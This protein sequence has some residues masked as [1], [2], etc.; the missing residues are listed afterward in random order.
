VTREIF[1]ACASSPG[2]R[3][4]RT[5][6]RNSGRRTPACTVAMVLASSPVRGTENHT[7]RRRGLEHAVDHETVEVFVIASLAVV[8]ACAPANCITGQSITIDSGMS[9]AL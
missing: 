2:S 5:N 1:T 9:V 8:L 7:V 3:P 6:A 4:R